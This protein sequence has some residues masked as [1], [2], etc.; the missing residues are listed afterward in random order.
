MTTTVE[1]IYENGV[2]RPLQPLP[3]KEAQHVTV[4]V[5]ERQ[6]DKDA[7]LAWLERTAEHRRQMREKFGVLP[8]STISIREDRDRDF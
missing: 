8:D 7:M 1:A 5:A 6:F 3:F 2:L 4:T